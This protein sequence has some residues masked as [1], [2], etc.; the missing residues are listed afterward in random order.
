MKKNKK[1]ILEVLSYALIVILVIFIKFYIVSH[2]KVNGDSMKD[3]L[4]DGDI[5]ILN[6]AAYYFNDIERFDIVVAKSDNDLEYLIKRVIGL[7]GET[8]SCVDGII[9]IDGKVLNDKY[10]YT[11]TQDFESIKI[12]KDQYF[13]MGDNRSVSLDSRRFGTFSESKIKGKASFTIYPFD[14]FGNKE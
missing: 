3:T 10:A 8:I 11:K 1:T 2:I 4:H 7:P 13:L 12:G 5:M 6:E 9:Y 14:R